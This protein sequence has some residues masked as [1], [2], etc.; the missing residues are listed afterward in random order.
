[1]EAAE[2][3]YRL[4]ADFNPE[5]PDALAFR[6]LV[7][8]RIQQ[9]RSDQVSAL[10]EEYE[11]VLLRAKGQAYRASQLRKI[12]EYHQTLGEL[13]GYLGRWGDQST[14]TSAIFQLD[15]AR[16]L[17]RNFKTEAPGSELV[18][19]PELTNLLATGYERTGQ[20]QKS[21]EVRLE[22]AEGFERSGNTNAVQKVIQPIDATVLT[23]R[24]QNRL[25]R[26]QEKTPNRTDR[27]VSAGS[28]E[29]VEERRVSPAPSPSLFRQPASR[30]LKVV[31]GKSDP[32]LRLPEE[33]TQELENVVK[34]LLTSSERSQPLAQALDCCQRWGRVTGV[35]FDGRNSGRIVLERSGQSF[36]VDFNVQAPAGMKLRELNVRRD[37]VTPNR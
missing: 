24:D 17:A 26:L 37:T 2:A 33:A 1:M 10:A 12:F 23:P 11:D 7:N 3:Y 29:A 27:D 36:R 21:V 25:E 6:Q 16:S 22:E 14:V 13:Y 19:S 5:E 8:L 15:R 9:G 20:P 28:R 18:F 34:R 32:A 30:E 31:L 4:A 35:S